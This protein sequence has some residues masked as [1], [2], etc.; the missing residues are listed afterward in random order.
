[1]VVFRFLCLPL[2]QVFVGKSKMCADVSAGFSLLCVH[3][4]IGVRAYLMGLRELSR[5]K[6]FTLRR[7]HHVSGTI[8]KA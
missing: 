4:I 7:I 3:A 2:V 8:R 5:N 1:M 6:L